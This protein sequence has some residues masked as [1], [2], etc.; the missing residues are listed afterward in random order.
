MTYKIKVSSRGRKSRKVSV[1]DFTGRHA[2]MIVKRS[3]K[4]GTTEKARQS[5]NGK[6]D[7]QLVKESVDMVDGLTQELVC[8][9]KHRNKTQ[10]NIGSEVLAHMSTEQLN[11]YARFIAFE[12][13]KSQL[14]N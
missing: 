10:I 7:Q 6:E 3:R 1:L 8:D 9:N 2:V 13:L 4:P 12:L 14:N 5:I 11:Q